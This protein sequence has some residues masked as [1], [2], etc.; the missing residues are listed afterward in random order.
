MLVQNREHKYLVH[1]L[2]QPQKKEKLAE[3]KNYKKHQ[4]N[5]I[6]KLQKPHKISNVTNTLEKSQ[7]ITIIFEITNTSY[8][9]L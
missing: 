5:Y 8:T 4:E 6:T 1:F 3:D 2:K 9:F 7:K